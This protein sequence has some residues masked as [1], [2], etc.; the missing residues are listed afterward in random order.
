MVR[1]ADGYP[2]T[3]SLRTSHPLSHIIIGERLNLCIGG[4]HSK[5]DSL[6]EPDEQHAPL[7]IQHLKSKTS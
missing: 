3:I 2:V 1:L 6:L 5:A 7:V 4:T